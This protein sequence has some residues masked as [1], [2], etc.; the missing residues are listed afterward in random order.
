MI[1]QCKLTRPEIRKMTLRSISNTISTWQMIRDQELKFH[2][3]LH[4]VNLENKEQQGPGKKKPDIPKFKNQAKLD[5]MFERKMKRFKK[6]G[7]R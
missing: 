1:S 3:A 5:A 6:H 2:A 4:G 7:K